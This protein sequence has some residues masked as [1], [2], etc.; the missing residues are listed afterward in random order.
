MFRFA[1]FCFENSPEYS[2]V[3]QFEFRSG[4]LRKASKVQDYMFDTAPI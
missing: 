3:L 4:I 1:K 2:G